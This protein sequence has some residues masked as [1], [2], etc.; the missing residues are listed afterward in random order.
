MQESLLRENNVKKINQKLEENIEL[1]PVEEEFWFKIQKENEESKKIC[2]CDNIY[3]NKKDNS[4]VFMEVK[5]NEGVIKT[6]GK[7][8][9]LTSHLNDIYNLLYNSKNKEEKSR[10]LNAL[11][12]RVKYKNE[13]YEERKANK[14]LEIYK[15]NY[16]IMFCAYSKGHEE[17]VKR[18]IKEELEDNKGNEII[19]KLKEKGTTT[20]L[21][22]ALVDDVKEV[23]DSEREDK[24]I[25]I[26]KIDEG[27]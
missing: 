5:Y 13:F 23:L 4:F 21:L 3:L 11:A 18:A 19:K 10:R 24:Y 20:I 17:V 8:P 12:R 25:K 16:F 6:Q 9:G 27:L 26:Q 22:T 2:R 15:D 14:S 7:N 1:R